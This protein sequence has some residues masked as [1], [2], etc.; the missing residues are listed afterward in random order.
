MVAIAFVIGVSED[1]VRTE[2][3]FSQHIDLEVA[4]SVGSVFTVDKKRQARRTKRACGS[5]F[6]MNMSSK[7]LSVGM[8]G[9]G[10]RSAGG[11]KNLFRNS[12]TGIGP[13]KRLAIASLASSR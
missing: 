4:R 8:H 5:P 9:E 12:S 13:T 6:R 2:T 7:I 1:K 3:V 10:G 11:G